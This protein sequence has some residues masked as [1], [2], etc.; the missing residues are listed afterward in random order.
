VFAGPEAALLKILIAGEGW[1]MEAPRPT[2]PIRV[3]I[4]DDAYLMREGLRRILG[5]CDGVEVVRT[6]DDL[7]S[8]RTAVREERPDAVLTDIR[9]PLTDNG[10]GIQVAGELGAGYP[11]VGMVVL[12][13]FADPDYMLALLES[14]AG[15]RAYLLK[16]RIHDA[17]ELVSAIETVA[18]GG[19]FVDPKVLDLVVRA[20][21]TAA[22]PPLS[23]LTH[24]E[25][26]VLALLSEGKSNAAIAESLDL[27]K[28][29]VEKHINAIFMKLGLASED[30]VSHRV[31]AA[32]IYLA[33]SG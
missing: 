29:A 32:L 6:V 1:R 27:T 22:K 17:G 30:E 3:V 16:E 23:D 26:E 19:S 11:E 8:L 5:D 9:M 12:S 24:R 7:D 14:G 13:Q 15:R 2:R 18:V 20:R 4:A 25:E 28:R 33:E 31:K 10:N 21:R